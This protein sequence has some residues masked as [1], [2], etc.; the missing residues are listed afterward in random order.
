MEKRYSCCKFTIKEEQEIIKDYESG[1]SMSKVGKKWNCD[2]TTVKNILRAYGKTGRSLSEA[3]RNYLGYTVNEDIFE[4]IDTPEKSYWL[5]VMY[6]DGY[7]TKRQ[8]TNFFGISVSSKDK[9]WLEKFKKFLNYNGD[10]HDYTVTSGYKI[11]TPYSR[12]II[13]NNKIVSDLE[14]MG[15][16]ERKTKKIKSLPDIP[17]LNDFIRG[18]IDGDGSLRRDYPCFQI[19]GN[20]SFLQEI[21]KY[22]QVDYRIYPDKSIYTLRYNT[23]QSE[24]LEKI[25]YKDATIF[26]QR[27][28]E[29]AKRSFNSPLT[30]EDVRI[31]NLEYQGNSLES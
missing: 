7:I 11:G 14:K 15:V 27:K 8:Y 21:A 2:P 16:I 20:L 13:G 31:K 6:S 22:L 12:I 3:R 26:L 9:E 10:I 18:Y 29:I 24:Y 23:K 1:L 28:Y 25:L 5:G 4:S 17:Y 19:S 30:L